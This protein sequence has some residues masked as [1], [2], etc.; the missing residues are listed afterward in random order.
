MG[1]RDASASKKKKKKKKKKKT[2]KARVRS[3][4]IGSD[5]H[6]LAH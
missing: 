4:P 2:K 1:L 5:K 6:V 3:V